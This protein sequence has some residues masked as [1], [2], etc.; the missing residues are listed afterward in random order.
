MIAPAAPA[1]FAAWTAALLLRAPAARGRARRAF[2]P[3]ALLPLALATAWPAA[4]AL[5]RVALLA[6]LAVALL[7]RDR[8]DT[9]QA[10]CAVKLL[11][12]LGAALALAWAGET[13]L[14]LA[15]GT[16]VA[17]EQWPALA[18]Q[19]DPYALWMSALALALLGGVVLLGGVP[20][21]F[22]AADVLQGAPA[23]LA[24]LLVAGVQAGGA[25]LLAHRLEGVGAF[26]AGEDVVRGVLRLAALLALVGGGATLAVQRRA[27][28]RVGTFASLQGGL[29]LAALAADP[30]HLPLATPD[31]APLAAWSAHLALALGGA[32]VF[33]RFVPA[34]IVAAPPALASGADGAAAAPPPSVPP[35]SA[36][37]PWAAAAGAYALLSLAGAP[38][39]PGA[40]VWLAV[41]RVVAASNSPALAL[42]LAFAW[43]AAFAAA[44]AD[45]RAAVLAA[46]RGAGVARLD[47]WTAAALVVAGAGLVAM[48][49]VAL[50]GGL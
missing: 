2:A 24:P 19:L 16:S 8:E 25:A 32:V 45:V 9:L 7:A 39:T 22:W 12:T 29:V 30:A 13:L 5:P 10:E 47:A 4:I 42:A 1:A 38:G 44:A 27:E 28:R 6:A 37:P 18:L 15:A 31:G 41:A 40:L 14:A 33:A 3:L 35:P 36:R 50:R 20:F 34:G 49:A 43:L 48:L 23:W 46:P 21:H 11:W 26:A 17:S